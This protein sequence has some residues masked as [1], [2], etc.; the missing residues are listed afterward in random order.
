MEVKEDIRQG[1][2][3]EE[4]RAGRHLLPRPRPQHEGGDRGPGS[5][6]HRFLG[7]GVLTQKSP[8]DDPQRSVV[9][10]CRELHYD[11]VLVCRLHPGDEL[12]EENPGVQKN[13]PN[14]NK[15]EQRNGY[16]FKKRKKSQI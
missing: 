10:F 13:K 4:D 15:P 16:A 3:P 6:R 14:V 8:E 2:T 12:R 7:Q 9:S 11:P 5:V 1:I